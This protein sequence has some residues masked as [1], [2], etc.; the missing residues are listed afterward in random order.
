M[1]DDH[2]SASAA[3]GR[4]RVLI[5]EQRASGVSINAFCAARGLATSSF[6]AWRRKLAT[7]A[8]DQ[9]DRFLAPAF[10]G[11]R[12]VADGA[13]EDRKADLAIEL[14]LRRGGARVLTVRGGFDAELLGR[15]VLT[16]ERI[17]RADAGSGAS[18]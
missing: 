11:V 5:D 9:A 14:H 4:W 13:D 1:S 12:S 16:V 7:A 8:P 10:V 3:A 2:S 17:D 15:L 18:Q 6:F